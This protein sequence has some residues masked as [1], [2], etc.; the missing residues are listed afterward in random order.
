MATTTV[1]D[2]AST[3]TY[4]WPLVAS[5]VVISLLAGGAPPYGWLLG[6]SS[7]AGGAPTGTGVEGS[8]TGVSVGVASPAAGVLVAGASATAG[9]V[10]PVA[11]TGVDEE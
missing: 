10:P 1:V 6:T 11:V 3:T 8:V 9:V 5:L 2:V 4:G 7:L